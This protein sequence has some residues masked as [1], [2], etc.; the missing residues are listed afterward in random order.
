MCR[1]FH[2]LYWKRVCTR[3]E[4]CTHPTD[5]RA[6]TEDAGWRFVSFEE[7]LLF[8]VVGIWEKMPP[9]APTHLPFAQGYDA[10]MKPKVKYK[11]T[12]DL[13]D[14]QISLEK[15]N[16]TPFFLDLLADSDRLPPS[17]AQAKNRI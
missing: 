15:W 17:R 10:C 11:N 13:S 6:R 2:E 12:V 9:H 1:E 3:E 7:Q 16:V 14:S 5:R 8:G 4:E